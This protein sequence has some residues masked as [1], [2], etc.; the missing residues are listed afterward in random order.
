VITLAS[1]ISKPVENIIA[2]LKAVPPF[3]LIDLSLPDKVESVANSNPNLKRYQLRLLC[4]T[5]FL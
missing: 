2:S 4:L 5:N 1:S 3:G